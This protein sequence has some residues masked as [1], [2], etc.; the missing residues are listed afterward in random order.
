[1]ARIGEGVETIEVVR[2]SLPTPVTLPELAPTP[3]P[4]PGVGPA[5][6]LLPAELELVPVGTSRGRDGGS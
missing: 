3:S 6:G 1:M 5:P 4:T 2:P